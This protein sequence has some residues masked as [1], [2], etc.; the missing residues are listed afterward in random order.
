MPTL[1]FMPWCRID[2]TYSVGEVTI[3]PFHS[4]KPLEGLDELATG[5]VKTILASYR[6]LEG[7]PVREAALVQYQ[8]R[9]LLE[10]VN[11]D[12]LESTWEYVDLA[13]FS[14]LAKRQYFN[15]LGPYCNT[16]CFNLYVQKFQDISHIA[17]TTRRREGQTLD[18]RPLSRTVFSIPTH[19]STIQR[20][21]LD[22]ALLDAL[23]AFR[24]DKQ[25]HGWNRWQSALSCFNQA[26][27][28]SNSV[29]Y[30]VEWVLLCGAFQHI[31]DAKSDAKDVAKKF[32]DALVPFTPL[33]VSEAERFPAQ[34]QW[35]EK[36]PLRYEWMKEFY[37]IRGDFAH[38]KLE[39]HK[40]TAWSPLEHIVLA[41]IAFSL[42]VRCLLQK[43]GRYKLI[44]MDE[45]QRDAFEKFADEE[46]L[47]PP[48][49][50]Q[51]S[52]DSIWARLVNEAKYAV[53]ERKVLEE[54]KARGLFGDE[55]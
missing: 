49:D 2:K 22:T 46:F 32:T 53:I 26:N 7:R 9:P 38:G 25:H 28:D 24:R 12:E 55:G 44:K 5:Q 10:D 48:K 8:N 47:K 19:V 33:G 15:S 23:T 16:D 39:T 37:Q 17:I 20:V 4:D 18:G 50:Q 13:C 51:S 54:L 30:Q 1:Q 31:L 35:D 52:I 41:T 43:Q 42:L 36:N 29:R 34:R 14:G 21:S 3:V 40:Q 11:N 6:D 45:A 27:T